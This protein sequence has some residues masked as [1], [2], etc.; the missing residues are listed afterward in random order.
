MPA[1][2]VIVLAGRYVAIALGS[3]IQWIWHHE[4]LGYLFRYKLQNM[5]NRRLH[6][7]LVY[8][9]IP[10]WEN[11]A[12][13]DLIARAEESCTWRIPAFLENF[14]SLFGQAAAYL[15]SCIVLMPFGWWI[16]AVVTLS[17]VPR[18]YLRAKHGS[19]RWSLYGKMTPETRRLWYVRRLL[20]MKEGVQ[21][22]RIFRSQG[23]LLAKFLKIQDNLFRQN[24]LVLERYFRA[25]TFPPIAE[26]LLLLT[27]AYLWLPRVLS[28]ALTVGSFTLLINMMDRLNSSTSSAA[29]EI[30]DMYESN[31]YIGY[32]FDVLNL[33]RVVHEV[34]DPIVLEGIT[35][36]KIEF[37]HVSFNYP[38]GPP[39]LK[40]VSF[41]I[42]PGEHIA[43][44]GPN[45]AGKTTIIKLLCRFY[46][47][48]DG[49]ILI[50][51]IDIRKLRL[52]SWYKFLGTLFQDFVRYRLSVRENI[53]LDDREADEARLV[54][55]A[56]DAGAYDFI[57]DLPRGFDQILSREFEGG[58]E[59]S[60]GQW[61][62]LAVA[63]AFYCHPP[64][65]IL[66]EPT[67]SIDAESEY[68]IF[69]NLLRFY[70]EKSLVFVSHRFS[71]V[72]NA[73]KIFVVED[74]RITER[75]THGELLEKGGKYAI[76]FK[77][78]AQG[79]R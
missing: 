76:M 26:T 4:Y 61:Q 17:T 41:V 16:P 56:K 58:C 21:E 13:Q 47:V 32:F 14:S 43:F 64:I 38:G 51:G 25:N 44:V 7:K 65:L 63:R 19:I 77:C 46:D 5:V 1:I 28:G 55:A 75:G 69:N 29:A 30:S 70:K 48:T 39:V 78:Q 34:K 9:D 67:S 53:V 12:T 23:A 68:A 15:S 22:A 10:H 73:N 3:Y 36:P 50:N 8:L 52:S 54:R 35:P 31:L 27:I 71:T 2:I 72:R 45:G 6:E 37:K 60:V 59:L 24:K 79:Y 62:K 49:E 57:K 11:H 42:T 33:P 20:S 66:D 18:L 74:G 40:D